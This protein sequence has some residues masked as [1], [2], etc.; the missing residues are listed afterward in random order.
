MNFSI[1][2]LPGWSVRFPNDTEFGTSKPGASTVDL[3][4]V[5]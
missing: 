3:V 1:D 4:S 5:L 2:D